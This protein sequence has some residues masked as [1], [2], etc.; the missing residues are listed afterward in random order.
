MYQGQIKNFLHGETLRIT[1]G[2]KWDKG[3][4]FG[5]VNAANV[6]HGL[7]RRI[8]GL[9]IYEGEFNNGHRTGFGREITN[10]ETYNCSVGIF[11]D[12]QLTP[13][14]II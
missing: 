4:Y 6:P 13:Q 10:D 9:T 8:G 14:K 12:G 1:A 7:G 3:L 11:L 2:M 5:M